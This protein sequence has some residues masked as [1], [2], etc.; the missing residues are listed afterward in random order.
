MRS[1]L[2]LVTAPTERSV[3]LNEARRHMRV[4]DTDSDDLIAMY[5]EAAEQSLAY[6][7]RALKPASYALDIYSYPLRVI[8]L[9]MPPLRTVTAVKTPD[10]TGVLTA[11]DTANYSIAQTSEGRGSL[12]ASTAYVWPAIA[13]SPGSVSASIE[14]TAGYDVVP[15]ALRAAILL[16]AGALY[17]NRSAVAPI[18]LYQM[19][20][21]VDALVS[22][23]REQVL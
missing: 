1:I 22:P 21:G 10:A 8:D 5:L 15:S 23:F 2:R 7:G 14:F 17:D 11:I 20:M 3:S 16:I 13:Y 4:E 6:V 12:V 18:S 9:P 19:P